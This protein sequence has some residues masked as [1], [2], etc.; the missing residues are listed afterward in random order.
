MGAGGSIP[1]SL[2]QTEAARPLDA[3]DFSGA[4][5]D[6]LRSEVVRVRNL[7]L[8]YGDEAPTE[9]AAASVDLSLRDICHQG[10][11]AE[12][13]AA[14]CL[15]AIVHFRK[16]LRQ[17]TQAKLRDHRRRMSAQGKMLA[18]FALSAIDVVDDSDDEGEGDDLPPMPMDQQMSGGVA[19]STRK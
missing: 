13:H 3:S 2:N 7:L 16:M 15:G 9:A 14:A 5:L 1:R 18:K 8:Q 12:E 19:T 11:S 17:P 10:S 6:D 4:S